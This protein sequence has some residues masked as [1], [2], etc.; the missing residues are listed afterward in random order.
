MSDEQSVEERL[1]V[2]VPVEAW[3]EYLKERRETARTQVHG[4]V[5][6]GAPEARQLWQRRDAELSREI[7]WFEQEEFD[8]GEPLTVNLMLLL[9]RVAPEDLP[10]FSSD[11]EDDDGD[12]LPSASQEG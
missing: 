3:L 4:A 2:E 11:E 6:A 10:M 9:N 5:E 7:E 1:L 12:E 8:D